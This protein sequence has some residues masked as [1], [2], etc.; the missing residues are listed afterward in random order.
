MEVLPESVAV[1]DTSSC[2]V[3][4]IRRLQD[5]LSEGGRL[6]SYDGVS[7]SIFQVNLTNG[8]VQ[9]MSPGCNTHFCYICGE[10]IIRSALRRDVQAATTAHYRRCRLFEDVVDNGVLP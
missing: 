9:C 4:I 8:P 5:A 2:A 1:S 7:Y 6:Q 3:L 10:A